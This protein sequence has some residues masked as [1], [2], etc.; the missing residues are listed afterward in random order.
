MQPD[1]I[2]C[3]H[4][5]A[6]YTDHFNS[7]VMGPLSVSIHCKVMFILVYQGQNK[8]FDFL[9]TA[10]WWRKTPTA[11]CICCSKVLNMWYWMKEI[12]FAP[13][14]LQ[15]Q[16]GIF[17]KLRISLFLLIWFVDPFTCSYW[18]VCEFFNLLLA[19]L[20]QLEVHPFTT[21][22]WYVSTWSPGQQWSIRYY[23]EACLLPTALA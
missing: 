22:L 3:C 13:V 7:N 12:H 23:K 8:L 16:N 19:M 5:Y 1:S 15:L 10:M 9:V 14:L 20:V 21:A 17:L 11:C 6:G 18:T 4:H 2:S